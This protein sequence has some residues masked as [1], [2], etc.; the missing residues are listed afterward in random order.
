MQ[1]EPIK[2]ENFDEYFNFAMVGVIFSWFSLI[3]F[4]TFEEEITNTFF[5][6]YGNLLFIVVFAYAATKCLNIFVCFQKTSTFSQKYRF[7][8]VLND[9]L[10]YSYPLS[11]ASMLFGE[12]G[13]WCHYVSLWL[14]ICCFS[15][16]VV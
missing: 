6:E 4:L 1:L 12:H 8:F 5:G 10:C 15:G 3:S 13:Y 2:F 9:V 16:K 14:S 7:V 11:F